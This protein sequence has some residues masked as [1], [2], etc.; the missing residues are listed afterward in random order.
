MIEKNVETFLACGTDYAQ[1]D[2]VRALSDRV[3]LVSDLRADTRH[4]FA[5][6]KRRRAA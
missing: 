1:A 5:E 2:T 3:S 4:I 6:Q